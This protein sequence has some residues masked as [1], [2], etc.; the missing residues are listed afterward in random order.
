MAVLGPLGASP[1]ME[2]DGK[3]SAL[4][5]VEA[6]L[7]IAFVSRWSAQ[8][9]VVAGSLKILPLRDLRM[10]RAFS[11]ATASRELHSGAG[12]FLAWARRNPPPRP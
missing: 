6:G 1:W 4:A 3:A 7:G 9:Q 5:Y 11:W 8:D 12:R 10:V 2:V